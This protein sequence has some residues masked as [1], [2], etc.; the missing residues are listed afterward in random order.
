MILKQIERI[1]TKQQKSHITDIVKHLFGILYR[2]HLSLSVIQY[3]HTLQYEKQLFNNRQRTF[4][5]Q[6]FS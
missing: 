4:Q 6:V 3:R 2:Y 5:K 1:S